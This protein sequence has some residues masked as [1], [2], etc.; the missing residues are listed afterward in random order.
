MCRKIIVP[1]MDLEAKMTSV[2]GPADTLEKLANHL[3]K[4]HNVFVKLL[5]VHD[6][7]VHTPLMEAVA[8]QLKFQLEKVR[9]DIRRALWSCIFAICVT[10]SQ[11]YNPHNDSINFP[12]S[13]LQ[14]QLAEDC[15]PPL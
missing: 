15:H 5:S 4:K 6:V 9:S 11:S 13:T 8:D 10:L 2:V 12:F 14:S 7:P 3:T 1:V